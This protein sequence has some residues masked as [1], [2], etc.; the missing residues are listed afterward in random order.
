[1][2]AVQVQEGEAVPC[3]DDECPGTA[4]IEM[5]NDL[6]YR[7]CTECGSTWGYVRITSEGEYCQVGIPEEVR[8]A[9]SSDVFETKTIPLQVKR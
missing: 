6:T 4:E 7:E 9:V 8:R 1:M 5:E 2:E 3:I